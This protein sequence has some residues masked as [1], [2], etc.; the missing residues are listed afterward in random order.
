M[1]LQVR[2]FLCPSPSSHKTECTW[3]KRPLTALLMAAVGLAGPALFAQSANR[4]LQAVD[5]SRLQALP[6]HHPMWASAENNIGPAPADLHLNQL[7]LVLSRSPRQ[8][9]AFE[10]L[11]ADQQNP[12]S[13]EF[14]R[15]LTPDEVGQRFGLSDQDIATVTTWLQSQGLH[16]NWVAPSRI[17]IGFGGTAADIGRAFQTEIHYYKVNGVQRIS[18]NSSPMIPAA[19]APA[20]KAIRGLYSIDEQPANHIDVVQSASPQMNGSSGSHYIAPADFD[21]IYDVPNG[22]TGAGIAI[23]IVSWSHTN[24]A[25]F[26]NFKIKTGL[27]FTDPT[28]VVPTTYGGVDPGPA[29]TTP[30]SCST[31]LGG[32]S[33]ATLDVLR[34]GS[35]APGASLLLVVSS[36][37]GSSDGLGADAQ[38]LVNTT[39]V[40]AQIMNISFGA[41]ES[42]AGPCWSRLLE[43][44]LSIRCRARASP[45]L[46]PPATPALPAATPHSQRRPPRPWPIAPTTFALPPT[47]HASAARSLPTPPTQPPTGLPPTARATNRL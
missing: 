6:N 19:L 41:C 46:S 40:P 24:P 29:Y 5:T 10:L 33:E 20:I 42:S 22:S 39:P 47:S 37:A 25:D 1:D 31:C 7:T 45:S 8:E 17:F 44:P 32:Q 21:L 27:T 12:A 26:D 23:G 13:P 43:H 35:V 18:V 4:I 28:E 34:A 16:V 15:W 36:P 30:Q 38:Y 11:L 14:H 2:T 3:V 9:Q